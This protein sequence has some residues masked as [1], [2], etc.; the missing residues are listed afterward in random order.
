MFAVR[1]LS[2]THTQSCTHEHGVYDY[3]KVTTSGEAIQGQVTVM[4]HEFSSDSTEQFPETMWSPVQLSTQTMSFQHNFPGSLPSLEGKCRHWCSLC[5]QLGARIQCLMPDGHTPPCSHVRTRSTYFIGNHHHGQLE[6]PGHIFTSVHGD[7]NAGV[8]LAMSPFLQCLNLCNRCDVPTHCQKPSGHV[9]MCAHWGKTGIC[10]WE[11]PA[12]D[13]YLEATLPVLRREAED[14]SHDLL[15]L[16]PLIGFAVVTSVLEKYAPVLAQ[17]PPSPMFL[18]TRDGFLLGIDT[19]GSLSI[20]TTGI[21]S[22]TTLLNRFYQDTSPFLTFPYSTIMVLRRADTTPLRI[23]LSHQPHA[24]MVGLG[25]YTSGE[26]WLQDKIGRR[27]FVG[28]PTSA[29]SETDAEDERTHQDQTGSAVDIFDRFF[30]FQAKSQLHGIHRT[31]PRT[32]HDHFFFLLFLQLHCPPERHLLTTKL[33][34]L[35]FPLP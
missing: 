14:M 8:A 15:R 13:A 30:L 25:P 35:G 32:I 28:H 11:P 2:S 21:P 17:F 10:V 6:V 7:G 29:M 20:P 31:G 26:L 24:V 19:D 33:Q 27:L 12:N 3:C 23:P 4:A 16:Y 9:E 1:N 5:A 18:P 22:L 34:A